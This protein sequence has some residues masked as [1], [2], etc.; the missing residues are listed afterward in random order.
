MQ[1]A[2]TE[3]TLRAVILGGLITVLFT[4]ANVYLGLKSGLTFA[5]SLPA[6]VI[7]MALLRFVSNSSILENNIVQ[8]VASAAGT[9][10]AIIFVLPGLLLL[11]VK[12]LAVVAIA[13][14]HAVSGIATIVVAKLGGAAVVARL[15]ALTL[16]TLLRRGYDP[17]FAC[18]TICAAGTLGQIIPPSTVMVILGEV[19][20]AAYQQAQFAQGKFSVETVSVGELF[21]A[22]KFM[23]EWRARQ[24]DVVFR[25]LPAP[26]GHHRDAGRALQRLPYPAIPAQP[27]LR[28]VRRDRHPA[29][30]E[31]LRAQIGR[32]HV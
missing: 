12:L 1:K 8:T 10:S 28:E 19:L 9:L 30:G 14:G 13:H 24:P 32:A 17:A 20:S 7:S 21:V 16:P 29:A 22:Q 31:P 26:A 27:G 25:L 4:A 6:A 2:T 15:Y 5:T 3:F 18:G 23:K 11:P